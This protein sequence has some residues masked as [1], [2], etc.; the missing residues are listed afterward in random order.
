MR[1]R[2]ILAWWKMLCYKCEGI[3]RT[4]SDHREKKKEKMKD[5]TEKMKDKEKK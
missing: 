5:K 2:Y 3:G 4:K 1:G